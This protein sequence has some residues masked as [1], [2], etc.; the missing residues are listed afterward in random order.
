[1]IQKR[2]RPQVQPREIVV[3]Q[4]RN[5]AQ[6]PFPLR[7]KSAMAARQYCQGNGKNQ[8]PQKDSV[9]RAGIEVPPDAFPS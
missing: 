2:H 6:E 8:M 3:P 7:D 4:A 1:M 5:T 9:R